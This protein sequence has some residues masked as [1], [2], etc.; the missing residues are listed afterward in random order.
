MELHG[1]FDD[2]YPLDARLLVV[3]VANP[4]AGADWQTQADSGRAWEILAGMWKLA[5]SATVATR[6]PGL[7]VSWAGATV[8]QAQDPGGVVASSSTVYSTTSAR[9][10]E[11]AA[12]V[13]GVGLIAAPPIYLP[14]G[15][16]IGSQ[17]KGIQAGDQYSAVNLLVREVWPSARR[18]EQLEQRLAQIAMVAASGGGHHPPR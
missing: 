11:P 9:L 18:V 8:W 3:P 13:Q 6:Y 4:A 2:P 7:A 14:P 10:I 17:T 5:C 1:Y 16:V 15:A 12:S